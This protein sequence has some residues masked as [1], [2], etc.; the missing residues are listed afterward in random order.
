M[1]RLIAQVRF[2]LPANKRWIIYKKATCGKPSKKFQDKFAKPSGQHLN[3]TYGA[4]HLIYG[5][6]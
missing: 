1:L 4:F 2:I 3:S 6:A 5:N